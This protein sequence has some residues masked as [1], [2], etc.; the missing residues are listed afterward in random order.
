MGMKEKIFGNVSTKN[1]GSK[2]F[3]EAVKERRSIY[4]IGKERTIS[5][6]NLQEVIQYAVLHTPSAFNS[7]SARVVVLLDYSHT[8]LWN[9]ITKETLRGIVPADQFSSTEEKMNSFANGYGTVLFFEDQD[10]IKGLQE[11][12]PTFA[13]NFP[14]WSQHS[15]GMLQFVIWTALKKEGLG[16]SLQHYNPLIDAQVKEEWD[17]PHSWELIAQMPFGNQ[18]APPGDKE[19][20]PVEGRV[21]FY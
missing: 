4:G 8:K 6:E 14:K 3:F 16:A 2:A 17:I 9:E 10:V 1:E 21:K 15:S 19:F 11:K 18:T 5:D 7:Q 12:L 20:Q 13:D